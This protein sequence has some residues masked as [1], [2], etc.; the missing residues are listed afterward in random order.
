MYVCKWIEFSFM[1]V[2]Y[3]KEV[4]KYGEAV[5]NKDAVTSDNV[6][7]L[8]KPCSRFTPTPLGRSGLRWEK[9]MKCSFKK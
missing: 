5:Q 8:E 4:S 6:T 3:N 2:T 1:T 7:I 9:K